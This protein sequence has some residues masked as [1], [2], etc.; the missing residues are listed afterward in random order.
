MSAEAVQEISSAFKKALIERALGAELSH[1]LGYALGT[2][3]PEDS[4]RS[5][6]Y[7]P[8][9]RGAKVPSRLQRSAADQPRLSVLRWGNL[10]GRR[11]K[12]DQNVVRGTDNTVSFMPLDVQYS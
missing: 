5:L 11:G 1:H 8:H 9:S 4:R 7:P 6:H 3:K 2:A 10:G 12:F